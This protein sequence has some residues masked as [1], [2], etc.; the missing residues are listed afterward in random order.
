M[1]TERYVLA[2]RVENPGLRQRPSLA[3]FCMLDH[4]IVSPDGGGFHG[5]TDT[6]LA[7]R[8]LTRRV[9]LSV[10][11]FQFLGAVLANTDLVAL[12]PSR[13]VRGNTALRITEPPLEVAGFEMLML[14]PE[15]LHR[16]P[17]HQWLR[18]RIASAVGAPAAPA[19]ARRP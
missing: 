1:F 10:P 15:R 6:A 3:K 4:V 2:G 7:E 5:V 16:A 11:H 17:A 13:L 14:W 18:A 9:A 8:G 12:V 19:P